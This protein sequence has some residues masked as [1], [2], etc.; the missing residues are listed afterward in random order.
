MTLA[1][2]AKGCSTRD[3]STYAPSVALTVTEV[4][5]AQLQTTRGGAIVRNNAIDKA[6]AAGGPVVVRLLF[7]MYSPAWVFTRYGSITYADPTPPDTGDVQ[8]VP[9]WKPALQ[10][11]QADFIAKLAALYDGKIKVIYI[12]TNMTKYAEPFQRATSSSA[13]RSALLKAGYTQAADKDSYKAGYNAF[14]PFKTTYLAQAFNPWQGVADDGSA[15]FDNDVTLRR[16]D[17]LATTWPGR[18][19]WANNSIREDQSSLGAGYADIYSK[20]RRANIDT[21][22]SIRFQTATA[23]RVGDLPTVLQWAVDHGAHAVELPV[24]FK[25][26]ITD[27]QLATYNTKL[28]NAR[29]R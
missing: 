7:G 28:K 9:W 14:A 29:T 1:A 16:M 6:L 11:D 5:W 10:A 15:V 4:T 24:G 20:M 2:S 26:L 25:A 12:A 17:V 3:T 19:I 22:R 21:G 27:A 23:D 13:N 18:A 8:I